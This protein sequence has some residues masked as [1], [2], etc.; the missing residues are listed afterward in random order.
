MSRVIKLRCDEAKYDRLAQHAEAVGAEGPAD[1]LRRLAVEELESA[2]AVESNLREKVA[3]D[4]RDAGWTRQ[5]DKVEA[6][7]LSLDQLDL[8]YD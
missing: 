4:L 5:A 6:G 2:S 8:Q 1:L 3:E 7:E